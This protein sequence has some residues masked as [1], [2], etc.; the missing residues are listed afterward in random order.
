MSITDVNVDVPQFTHI[1]VNAIPSLKPTNEAMIDG[2]VNSE[3]KIT[4]SKE[5][6]CRFLV[7]LQVTFNLESD[8]KFLYAIDVGCMCQLTVDKTVIASKRH[9][10]AAQAAHEMLFPAIREMVLSITSRQP[11]GPFSI[12]LGFLKLTSEADPIHERE[13]APAPKRIRRKSVT[14]KT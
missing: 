3:L 1:R 13:L 8:P 2:T 4:G 7:N 6:N 5:N 12:G 10:R 11:W 14:A 9:E